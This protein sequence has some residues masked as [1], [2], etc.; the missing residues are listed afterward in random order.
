LIETK[1]ATAERCCSKDSLFSFIFLFF[2]IISRSFFFFFSSS[3]EWQQQQKRK[4]ILKYN[5]PEGAEAE[6]LA[7]L[8]S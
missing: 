1:Y 2:V 8:N 3:I 4:E 5:S 6:P 7:R